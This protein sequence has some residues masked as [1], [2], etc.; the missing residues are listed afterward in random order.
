MD[1]PMNHVRAFDMEAWKANPVMVHYGQTQR[2]VVSLTPQTGQSSFVYEGNL[3]PSIEQDAAAVIVMNRPELSFLGS[4]YAYASHCI[5]V[6]TCKSEASLTLLGAEYPLFTDDLKPFTLKTFVTREKVIE[7]EKYLSEMK[8]LDFIGFMNL[9]S[10][11]KIGKSIKNIF[12][13]I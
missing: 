11:S 9:I 7:A 5:P 2:R 6:V 4:L 13:K 3:E 1:I 12:D 10:R 8:R